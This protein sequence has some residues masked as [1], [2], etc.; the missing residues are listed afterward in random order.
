MTYRVKLEHEML[1]SKMATAV[2]LFNEWIKWCDQ[3][4]IAPDKISK[5]PELFSMKAEDLYKKGNDV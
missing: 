5:I 2:A 3:N 4:G 1:D